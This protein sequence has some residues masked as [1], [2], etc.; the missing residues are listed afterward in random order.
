[1]WTNSGT[2]T[3]TDSWTATD[4]DGFTNTGSLDLSAGS[5]SLAFGVNA[6]TGFDNGAEGT[7]SINGPTEIVG[8][9]TNGGSISIAGTG[10]LTL[11]GGEGT[12]GNSGTI[13]TDGPVSVTSNLS[14]TNSGTITA[15]ADVSVT[16][17]PDEPGPGTY[18][19]TET[20]TLTLGAD[21]VFSVTN[22]TLLDGGGALGQGGTVSLNSVNAQFV[23]GDA[24]TLGSNGPNTLNLSGSSISSTSGVIVSPGAAGTWIDA[25]VTGP[26]VNQGSLA[27]SGTNTFNGTVLNDTGGV[28]DIQTGIGIFNGS[29]TN[30]GQFTSG[31]DSLYVASALS[32]GGDLTFA[33]SGL[34]EVEVDGM[35]QNLTGGTLSVESVTDGQLDIYS[36]LDILFG[37][38][39]VGQATS[40]HGDFRNRAEVQMAADLSVV[41]DLTTADLTAET[42]DWATAQVGAVFRNIGGSP[43]LTVPAMSFDSVTMVG[44]PLVLD[45]TAFGVADYAFIPNQAT[46]LTFEGMGAQV[47][48]SILEDQSSLDFSSILFDQTD[49]NPLY[50]RAE[51]SDPLDGNT[52][53]INM[54]SSGSGV[55][56]FDPGPDFYELLA[57]AVL[58]GWGPLGQGQ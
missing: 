11:S 6:T 9:F 43:V 5:A 15:F 38:M 14:F 51:D 21:Q 44:V 35:F 3:V 48:L 42:R 23:S 49:P 40:V 1:V 19:Q 33:N 26:T 7:V 57:G 13:T 12:H 20:G 25:T 56:T 31:A 24:L 22:G 53:D 10:S 29:L 2:L 39:I 52:L 58:N 46:N 8:D 16:S 27:L 28:W 36:S 47:Q 55:P 17:I 41:N 30:S 37:L 50:F 4:L 54:N 45:R 34:D 18:T 32:N